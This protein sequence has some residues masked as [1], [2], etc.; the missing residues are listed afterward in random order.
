VQDS[1]YAEYAGALLALIKAR[2]MNLKNLELRSD[3]LSMVNQV[4]GLYETPDELI[5]PL[6][7]RIKQLQKQF[8]TIRFIHVRRSFN[9]MADGI[10]NKILDKA[11]KSKS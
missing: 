5:A 9:Q 11:E 4:N 2:S 3:S 6:F 10:V 8:D 7:H 1:I